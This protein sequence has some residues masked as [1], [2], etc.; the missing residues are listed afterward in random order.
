MIDT[1]N[2]HD[3][4][5]L[6]KDNIIINIT[7]SPTIKVKF[8]YIPKICL[9]TIIYNDGFNKVDNSIYMSFK[10]NSED[11]LSIKL[12]PIYYSEYDNI[13]INNIE[14]QNFNSISLVYPDDIYYIELKFKNLSVLSLMLSW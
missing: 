12:I 9:Y 5:I 14:I 4:F 10:N 3:N 1:T 8:S 13:L 7:K 11:I 6:Y 2:Y